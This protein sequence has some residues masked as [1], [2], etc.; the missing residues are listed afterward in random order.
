VIVFLSHLLQVRDSS[1]PQTG[2]GLTNFHTNHNTNNGNQNNDDLI[3]CCVVTF[4]RLIV[5]S[6]HE[7]DFQ[8]PPNDVNNNTIHHNDNNLLLTNETKH[9][10]E[11]ASVSRQYQH[12]HTSRNHHKHN[13]RHDVL[14]M[15]L[16]SIDKI[17]KSTDFGIH[18]NFYSSTSN[19]MTNSSSK[20]TTS[21]AN[22]IGF[23]NAAVNF[24]SG[25]NNHISNSGSSSSSIMGYSSGDSSIGGAV[26]SGTLVVYGKDNG[27][28]IQFTTSSYA[29]CMRVYESLNTYAFPGRRNLGYL[30]AFES[31]RAEVMASA[32]SDEKND[33][34]KPNGVMRVQV[35]ATP[36]R[37]DAITEFTR[38]VSGPNGSNSSG[39]KCP[40]VPVL[41]ANASY[42]LCSSYP[43]V[44]FVPNTVDDSKPEGIRLLRDTA[45]F[46]S[47]GR[48]QTLSWASRFDGAS[49]W[50]SAQ[51]KVGL[52]GNRSTADELYMKK[53]AECAALANSQAAV[54]GLMPPR[55]SMAFLKML[56]GCINES[57]LMLENFGNKDAAAFNEKCMLKIFDLR[58]LRSAMA[59]KTQGRYSNSGV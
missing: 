45:S 7:S 34:N 55:P 8:Q 15:P 23:G 30:F 41:K 20:T 4:Y 25:G 14:Q 49:L 1:S 56:T 24:I 6:Y 32:T 54:N 37:Y 9:W 58:P 10:I 16:A 36:K 47:G 52:Q 33:Q 53:I 39:I 57:D 48:F 13:K 46:R 27:R 17:E 59:N 38:M 26:A 44:L 28:F 29:D 2:L 21:L 3:W 12:I 22:Q 18:P 11:S 51:P 43:S 42:N 50:R 19:A 35:R 40:W 31:R 5:F